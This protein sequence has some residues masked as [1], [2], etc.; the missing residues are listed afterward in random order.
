[1]FIQLEGLKVN[2]VDGAIEAHTWKHIYKYTKKNLD[3]AHWVRV[4]TMLLQKG[5]RDA[6]YIVYYFL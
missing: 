6:Q 1:M 4:R 5:E 3:P 2:V